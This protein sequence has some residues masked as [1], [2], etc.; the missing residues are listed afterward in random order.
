M[1]CYA[2]LNRAIEL[3]PVRIAPDDTGYGPGEEKGGGAGGGTQGD[4]SSGPPSFSEVK[5]IGEALH[6]VVDQI[7][8]LILTKTT[9]GPS[10]TRTT[11]TDMFST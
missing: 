3:V 7:S 8:S 1:L 2:C 6:S 5:K 9:A 11:D 4:G 10:T